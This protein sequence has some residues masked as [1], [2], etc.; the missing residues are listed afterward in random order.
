LKNISFGKTDYLAYRYY[1]KQ[2]EAKIWIENTLNVELSDD[3]SEALQTGVRNF[4]EFSLISLLG[5]TVPTLQLLFSW[6]DSENIQRRP[7]KLCLQKAPKHP[8]LYQ[9]GNQSEYSASRRLLSDH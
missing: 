6:S 3:L 4:N 2:T 9:R 8:I 1:L 5:C 7:L